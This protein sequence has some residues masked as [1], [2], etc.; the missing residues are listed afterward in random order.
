MRASYAALVSPYR[1]SILLHSIK[2]PYWQVYI[3]YVPQEDNAALTSETDDF[4]MNQS[5]KQLNVIFKDQ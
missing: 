5:V 2:D 4:K 3:R 1:Y